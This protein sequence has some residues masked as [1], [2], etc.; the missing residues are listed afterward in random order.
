MKKLKWLIVIVLV[1]AAVGCGVYFLTKDKMPD[2]K[3]M[4]QDDF[5]SFYTSETTTINRDKFHLKYGN[6]MEAW[7]DNSQTQIQAKIVYSTD[8]ESYV[9]YLFNGNCYVHHVDAMTDEKFVF[10][11]DF[12][13]IRTDYQETR[14]K[15]VVN[16][17]APLKQFCNINGY[18]TN[19]MNVAFSAPGAQN[20]IYKTKKKAVIE[21]NLKF[22]Y[23]VAADLVINK[24]NV[25]ADLRFTDNKL[26]ELDFRKTITESGSS[27]IIKAN[28]VF[29]Y[30]SYSQTINFPELTG[31]TVAN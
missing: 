28:I 16:I 15:N 26:V 7:F 3:Q 5:I 6:Q 2:S 9:I 10:E 13:N 24:Y 8:M 25:E 30:E 19:E 29:N 4:S 18:L 1:V 27:D 17:I 31:Y 14:V 20:T 11:I 23:D 21:Y 22:N 12:N